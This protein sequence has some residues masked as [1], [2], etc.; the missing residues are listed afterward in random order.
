[1]SSLKYSVGASWLQYACNFPHSFY[2]SPRLP[3]YELRSLQTIRMTR[4]ATITSWASFSMAF[5]S[6]LVVVTLK[7]ASLYNLG[8]N[9]TKTQD[10]FPRGDLSSFSAIIPVEV[11]RISII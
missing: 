2:Q 7:G 1:M 5:E 4:G 3:K 8:K 11:S 9:Y 10:L 6:Y